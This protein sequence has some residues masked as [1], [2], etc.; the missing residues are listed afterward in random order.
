LVAGAPLLVMASVL[1][2][3]HGPHAEL[4]EL[5]QAA[6]EEKPD[7]GAT[8]DCWIPW[9]TLTPPCGQEAYEW[10]SACYLP[11]LEKTRAPTSTKPQ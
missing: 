10:K 8:P 5:A 7:A 11:S 9:T 1:W 2:F 3:G 6:A 4:P